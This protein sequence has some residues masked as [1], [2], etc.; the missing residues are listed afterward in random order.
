MEK[1]ECCGGGMC[2]GG[3]C[4]GMGCMHGCHGGKHHLVKIILKLII[5]GIIFCFGFRLGA[6]TG[7]LKAQ[8]GYGSLKGGDGFGWGMMRG[9]NYSDQTL[10]GTKTVPTPAPTTK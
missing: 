7:F 10:P 4:G 6:M 2:G 9:Y 3:S 1:K 5:I 8:S